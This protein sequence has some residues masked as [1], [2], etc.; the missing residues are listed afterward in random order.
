MKKEV[1]VA[2]DVDEDKEESIKKSPK[3][4]K[5]QRRA[6]KGEEASGKMV[7]KEDELAKETSLQRRRNL[8]ISQSD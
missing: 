3:I 4:V 6:C 1:E 8:F 2:P 7:K 5:K